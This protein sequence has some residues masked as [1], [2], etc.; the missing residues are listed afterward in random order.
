M[1]ALRRRGWSTAQSQSELLL[2]LEWWRAYYHLARPHQSLRKKL[3][4][5]RLRGGQQLPQ[6]YGKRTP[7]IAAGLTER[8]WSVVELLSYPL[9]PL[10]LQMAA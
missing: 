8:V 10:P 7:A 9:P 2:H 1:A 3:G 6:G 4:H 5:P